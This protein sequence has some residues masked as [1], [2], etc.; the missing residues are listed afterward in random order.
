MKKILCSLLFC[1]SVWADDLPPNFT[2][3]HQDDGY[4]CWF[5]PKDSFTVTSDDYVILISISCVDMNDPRLEKSIM[6]FL[7]PL[8]TILKENKE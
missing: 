7:I 1:F 4:L 8:E 5:D 2:I 3:I 6:P